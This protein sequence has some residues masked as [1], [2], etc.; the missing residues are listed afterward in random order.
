M[1][2]LSWWQVNGQNVEGLRHAE[3]VAR[4]KARGDE[5]RLLV[6][7]PETDEHFKRL[8]VTPTEEHVEGGPLPWGAGCGQR[9][10]ED[11]PDMLS[12]QV[13]CH[14]QSPTGPALPR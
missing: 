1:L 9:G 12:P 8:R 3:V 14:R 7:D 4:I 6:V 13:H 5:A 2:T 10:D 11:A